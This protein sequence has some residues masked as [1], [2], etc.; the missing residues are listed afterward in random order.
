MD[1][2]IKQATILHVGSVYHQKKVDIHISEG[3]IKSI[4]EDINLQNANIISGND[5]YCTIGLCDIGTHSG[6]PGFEHR[7]TIDSLSK[8]A[9]AGGYSALAVFPNNKPVTQTRASI[10]YIKEN[11][12][13]NGVQLYPIGALSKDLKGGDITEYLDMHAEGVVAFSDGLESVSD[14]GL[15]GRALQYAAITGVPI[16][17]HP[18]DHY[19]NEGREMHEGEMSTSLGIKGEPEIAE[20]NAVQRDILIQQYN[21]S[22]L[23]E[24]AIS[25]G[26][27]VTAIKNAK[28]QT[29]KIFSTVSYLN[30]L[31]TDTDLYDFDSNL[32]VIPVLRSAAD[33]LEL[34]KGLKDG[35]IDA[36]VSNH[37]AL[38]EEVKNLEF[39]YATAGA[40]GLETCLIA[41]IEGLSKKLGLDEILYKLTIGPR[42]ILNLD[43]P[44]I[45]EGV[46]ANLCIFDINHTWK[47][48]TQDIKSKS[49]NSPFIN[50][51]FKTKV[52]ATFV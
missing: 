30:L 16:I 34:I 35:T 18:N 36:I 14:T 43:I 26:K 21:D 41:S 27:S 40:I 28:K 19:L 25:S 5:L 9:L 46:K 10:R 48:T 13:R 51:D 7:E 50:K 20:L 38:D 22:I 33:Q 45:K 15:L 47:Y 31:K 4:A 6:E 1:S 49:K 11:Q 24:H 44:E 8:S 3:K 37:L 17:H 52:I 2:I 32:K 42:K 39:P 23:I 29:S 12:D